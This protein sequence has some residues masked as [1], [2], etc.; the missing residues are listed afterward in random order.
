[1]CQ[2]RHTF[3]NE[4][5]QSAGMIDMRVGVYDVT[6]G[7]VRYE[8]SGLRDNRCRPCLALRTLNYH[9]VVL[10]L[11]RETSVPAQNKVYPLGKL[12]GWR[13]GGRAPGGGRSRC[14]RASALRSLD[15]HCTVRRHADDIQVEDWMPTL[16]LYD[17]AGKFHAA[18]VFVARVDRF[19][20]HVTEKGIVY[21][22]LDLLDEVVRVDKPV[23]RSFVLPHETENGVLLSTD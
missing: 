4:S 16:L 21:P 23:N 5:S 10:E 8:L 19:E 3:R 1:M 14:G 12:L 7:F 11:D 13:V 18:K 6:N 20:K 9:D 2:D 17:L 22:R 15:A